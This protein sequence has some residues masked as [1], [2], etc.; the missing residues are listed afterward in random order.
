MPESPRPPLY[1]TMMGQMAYSSLRIETSDAVG[2]R[3]GCGTG[4]VVQFERGDF[5]LPLII[6]ARHIVEAA[7]AIH[8]RMHVQDDEEGLAPGDGRTVS[9]D[10]APSVVFMH[11]D[12]DV[13][14]AAIQLLHLNTIAR[15]EGWRPFYRHL[16]ADSL[17]DIQ[18]VSELEAIEEV[19]MVGYPSGLFDS[20]NNLPIV[21]RGIT[22]TPMA[23]DYEGRPEFL[24]DM[25]VYPGSSGSPIFIRKASLF[26]NDKGQLQETAR[27]RLLGILYGGPPLNEGKEGDEA[28]AT[29]QPINLG[30]CLKAKTLLGFQAI[31][32][33]ANVYQAAW[34]REAQT[35][36]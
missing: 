12:P 31:I 18:F 8:V 6:T 29:A 10:V 30:V 32:Q 11:P 14:L 3:V 21:R 4:F 20:H 35:G 1:A 27:M 7:A 17:S 33:K 16:P 28:E 15:Q 2:T 25:P 13:D 19:Y 23:T 22:A 24:I 36:S 5:K 34:E 9:T 26:V